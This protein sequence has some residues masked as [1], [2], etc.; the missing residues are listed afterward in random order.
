MVLSIQVPIT[1][2][3]LHDIGK[4]GWY[5]LVYLVFIGMVV[6][7]LLRPFPPSSRFSSHSRLWS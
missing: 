7:D 2:Q 1:V 4:S 6:Y 5:A 3:R